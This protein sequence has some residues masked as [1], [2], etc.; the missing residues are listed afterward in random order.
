MSGFYNR[1]S[2]G[3]PLSILYNGVPLSSAVTSIDF[4]GAGQTTTILG[5]AVTVTIPGGAFGTQVFNEVPSGTVN[6]V[7]TVFTFANTPVAATLAVYVN[8]ARFKAGGIDFT[9]VTNT[10]TFVTAPPTGS[11]ILADYEY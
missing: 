7:N 6:N 9:L 1:K 8:G 5:S 3:T 2:S 4:E 11:I 10:A